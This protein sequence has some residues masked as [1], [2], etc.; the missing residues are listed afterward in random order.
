MRGGVNKGSQSI[1]IVGIIKSRPSFVSYGKQY[2]YSW[3]S[4][5]HKEKIKIRLKT[6][7]NVMHHKKIIWVIRV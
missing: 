5:M 2:A 3:V 6:N 1:F 7:G 4:N